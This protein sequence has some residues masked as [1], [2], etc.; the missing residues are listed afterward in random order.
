MLHSNLS[1]CQEGESNSDSLPKLY[2]LHKTLLCKV[3]QPCPC[4]LMIADFIYHSSIHF[5]NQKIFTEQLFCAKYFPE[6]QAYRRGKYKFPVFVK[7]VL[8]VCFYFHT[9]AQRNKSYVGS[10]S[11]WYMLFPKIAST[12]H[13]GDIA[14]LFNLLL[15]SFK[16]TFSSEKDVNIW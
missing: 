3:Q 16:S 4:P 7:L 5:F 10:S 11:K 9:R 1:P 6:C 15:L 13:S 2:S 14:S 8:N 12:L